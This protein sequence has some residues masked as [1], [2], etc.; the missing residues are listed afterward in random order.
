MA[1]GCFRIST[2]ACIPASNPSDIE[3]VD[4]AVTAAVAG[5]DT[6]YKWLQATDAVPVRRATRP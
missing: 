3:Q 6:I 5:M 1:Y 4:A 2:S